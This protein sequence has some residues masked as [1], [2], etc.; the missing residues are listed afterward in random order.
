MSEY[1]RPRRGDEVEAWI[2]RAR[3]SYWRGEGYAD[4]DAWNALDNLLDDY[5][6]HADTGTSL[7]TEASEL[8]GHWSEMQQPLVERME[9]IAA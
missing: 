5:R 4:V 9:P 7:D 1:T 3:D 8:Q 2:K 6:L